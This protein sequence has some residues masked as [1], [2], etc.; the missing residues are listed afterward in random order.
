MGGGG[1][2]PSPNNGT[3]IQTEMTRIFENYM[4]MNKFPMGAKR[5]ARQRRAPDAG[6]GYG[7]T[8]GLRHGQ[9]G[10]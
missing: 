3:K 2:L 7:G 10:F 6:L 8:A 1:G 5:R 4:G 9:D